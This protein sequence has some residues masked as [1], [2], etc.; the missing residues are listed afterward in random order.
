MNL[1][2]EFLEEPPVLPAPVPLLELGLDLIPS[3][4]PLHRVTER[5]HVLLLLVKR[6]VN[7]VTGRHEVVV[8]YHLKTK[9]SFS[10]LSTNCTLVKSLTQ[11]RTLS[12][13]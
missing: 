13:F 8:V 1:E 4:L 3:L 9:I 11:Q 6:N 7:R 5:L 12:S 2:P 10:S